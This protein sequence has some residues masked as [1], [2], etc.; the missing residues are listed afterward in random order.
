LLTKAVVGAYDADA[1]TY[2]NALTGTVSD[3][4]KTLVNNLVVTLKNDGNWSEIDHL[5]LMNMPNEQ[6]CMVN[7]IHPSDPLMVNYNSCVHTPYI[8]IQ[9]NG[10]NAYIDTNYNPSTYGG[11]HTQNSA[12]NS[13][14]ASGISIGTKALNGNSITTQ[15]YIIPRNDASNGIATSNCISPATFAN[16]LDNGNFSTKRILNSNFDIYI[17]GVLNGNYIQS[18]GS[19]E[20]LTMYILGANLNNTLALPSDAIVKYNCF[21]SGSINPTTFNTAITTFVNA[22]AAL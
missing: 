6:N 22:M 12:F 16:T 8:G 14:G 20:N 10:T 7:L 19:L 9:G 2:F 18:S 3:A 17:N 13:V 21:G 4:V 15:N 5:P 11:N 1:V